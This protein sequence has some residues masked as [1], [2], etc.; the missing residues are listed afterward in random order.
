MSEVLLDIKKWGNSLGM[1]LPAAVA[2]EAHLHLD[3]K[4]S[5]SVEQGRVIISPVDNK[6]ITLEERLSRYNPK[7][8]RGE[9]MVTDEL[10]GAEKW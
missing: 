6:F 3:Q 4:V 1:R 7:V 10:L 8:H 9:V 5:L 2:K